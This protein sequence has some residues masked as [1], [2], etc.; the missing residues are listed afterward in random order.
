MITYAE[1]LLNFEPPQRLSAERMARIKDRQ[2]WPVLNQLRKSGRNDTG[3]HPAAI[4][5]AIL[6]TL[7][8]EWLEW[9]DLL[10]AINH[11]TPRVSR[12]LDFLEEKGRIES[13]EIYIYPAACVKGTLFYL[14]L[15]D[16]MIRPTADYRGYQHAYRLKP[17]MR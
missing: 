2:S 15:T 10:R 1:Q 9:H 16:R 13:I 11:G 3:Y 6:A 5:R 14:S 7:T 12:V 4:R 8:T 17:A